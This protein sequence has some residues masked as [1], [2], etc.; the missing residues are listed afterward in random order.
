MWYHQRQFAMAVVGGGRMPLTQHI[1]A[2]PLVS[3]SQRC[4]GSWAY[5]HHSP[6]YRPTPLDAMVARRK[7]K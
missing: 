2:L 1:A 6:W 7:P 5:D 3:G 4:A